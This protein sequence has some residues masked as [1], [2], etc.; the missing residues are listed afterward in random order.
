M[1]C[2][3]SLPLPPLLLLHM[4]LASGDRHEPS[5]LRQ[6]QPAMG[7]TSKAAANDRLAALKAEL[8]REVRQHHCCR[9]G[10]GSMV[11]TNRVWQTQCT[12]DSV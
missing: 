5:G 4:Q 11:I 10:G 7:V 6:Q 3:S 2:L 9:V 8:A 12:V 1:F